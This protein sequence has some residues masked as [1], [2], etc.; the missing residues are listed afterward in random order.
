MLT[1]TGK[2]GEG[3]SGI[4][5]SIDQAN[6]KR[7]TVTAATPMASKGYTAATTSCWIRKKPAQC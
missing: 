5:F 3:L 6:A 4:A 7:T 1:A 2:S